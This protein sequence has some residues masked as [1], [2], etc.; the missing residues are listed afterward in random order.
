MPVSAL[1]NREVDIASIIAL[2]IAIHGGD[3]APSEIMIDDA[4]AGLIAAALDSH[5]TNTVADDRREEHR[6]IV[7]RERLKEFG[8]EVLPKDEARHLESFVECFRIRIP[9]IY[10]DDG[11]AKFSGNYRY[12][13]VCVRLIG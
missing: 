9:I 12:V 6:E 5:L 7:L 8:V 1:R 13:T 10:L 2:W 11:V 3:P 4:T